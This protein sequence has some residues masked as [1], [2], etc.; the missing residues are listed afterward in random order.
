MKAWVKKC[1][2]DSETS[3]WISANTKDCPKCRSAIEKNGGWYASF[4][5]IFYFFFFSSFFL[6]SCSCF[7]FFLHFSS[8]HMTCRKCKYE[9]CWICMGNWS[10]HSSC[11]KFVEDGNK[12]SISPFFSLPPPPPS[13]ALPLLFPSLSPF[14]FLNL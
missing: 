6:S 14:P 2:D 4:L 7:C 11:N 3:N 9:F 12:V 13:L 10:G 1:Q 8:N 5:P